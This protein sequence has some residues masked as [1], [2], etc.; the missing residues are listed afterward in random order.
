[1]QQRGFESLVDLG[2]QPADMHVDHIGLG[3]EMIFPHAFQQHG[4]GHHLTG[5]AH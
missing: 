4:T 3:I 2:A 1:M 5:M